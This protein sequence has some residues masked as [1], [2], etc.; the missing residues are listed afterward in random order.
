M[1]YYV[2]VDA[3]CPEAFFVA[4]DDSAP[5]K[6][7]S[8]VAAVTSAKD[9]SGYRLILKAVGQVI[10]RTSHKYTKIK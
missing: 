6:F 2:L 7:E 3:D 10:E 5:Q 8:E 4:G 9:F 1:S